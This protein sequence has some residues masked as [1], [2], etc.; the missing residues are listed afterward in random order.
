M[1][2]EIDNY[3][4]IIPYLRTK[5]DKLLSEGIGRSNE[6]MRWIRCGM[7]LY[8]DRSFCDDSVIVIDR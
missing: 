4:I 7:C 3:S 8:A 2:A 1:I 6:T 5:I